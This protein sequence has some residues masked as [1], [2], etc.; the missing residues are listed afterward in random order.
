VH[1]AL[2]KQAYDSIQPE[3]SLN[4]VVQHVLMEGVHAGGGDGRVEG[5]QGTV[6][7]RPPVKESSVGSKRL[8]SACVGSKREENR[9][10]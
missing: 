6:D 1:T 9:A 4:G 3:A 10:A 8:S 7:P 5:R 2:G